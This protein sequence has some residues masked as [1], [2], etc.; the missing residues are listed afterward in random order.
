[1]T[2]V[3]ALIDRVNHGVIA[4]ARGILR[5]RTARYR[6]LGARTRSKLAATTYARP[7]QTLIFSFSVKRS[8]KF[9]N[10]NP[11]FDRELSLYAPPRPC[12]I[13][14]PL[15]CRPKLGDA[16]VGEE[17]VS[18]IRHALEERFYKRC[19][20]SR[21]ARGLPSEKSRVFSSRYAFARVFGSREIVSAQNV[22]VPNALGR[23]AR[24]TFS[25]LVHATRRVA[26]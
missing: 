24:R 1:M 14:L 4:V 5:L 6:H 9:A 19:F 8:Q 18:Q 22:L 20:H 25:H 17:H 11:R 21:H 15:A 12:L 7:S 2:R 10:F 13:P 16:L 23:R 3:R 26:R